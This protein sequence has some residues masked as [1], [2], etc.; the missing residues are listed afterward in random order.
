MISMLL[1]VACKTALAYVLLG[2]EGWGVAGVAVSA[3][4]CD[5]VIVAANLLFI[6]CDAPAMLP[7][8]STGVALFGGPLALSALSVAVTETLRGWGGW[9]ES[10]PLH[11]LGAVACVSCLYGAGALIAWRCLKVKSNEKDV[12][13]P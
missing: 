9:Q 10:T 4:V 1:G 5:T 13:L 7:S 8:C 12:P 6:R 2:R 11:T 3:L